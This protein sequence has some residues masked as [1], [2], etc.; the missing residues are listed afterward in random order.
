VIAFV[1]STPGAIG[2]VAAD[3]PATG[4]KTIRVE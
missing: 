4:V 2:Y 3:T 1:R